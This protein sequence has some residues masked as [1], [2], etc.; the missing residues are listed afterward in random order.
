MFLFTLGLYLPLLL[1]YASSH[2][3]MDNI[4][5]FPAGTTTNQDWF[6]LESIMTISVQNLELAV[7]AHL[8]WALTAYMKC[9]LAVILLL[10]VHLSLWN[11]YIICFIRFHFTA[12]CVIPKYRSFIKTR[13][14]VYL[15]AVSCNVKYFLFIADVTYYVCRCKKKTFLITAFMPLCFVE[16][17]HAN[18]GN[19]SFGW[20]C[21]RGRIHKDIGKDGLICPFLGPV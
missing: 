5:S 20:W 14:V 6:V 1:H 4:F 8:V 19:Y 15:Y 10:L 2:S 3:F 9:C 7:F 16:V 13:I 18:D 21:I 17:L 11:M 12:T